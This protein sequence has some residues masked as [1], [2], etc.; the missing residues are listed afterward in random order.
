MIFE[1]QTYLM[2][3]LRR[4]Y[5]LLIGII[6]F[7][8]F[9]ALFFA[10]KWVAATGEVKKVQNQIYILSDGQAWPAKAYNMNMVERKKEIEVFTKWLLD[11][12]FAH[13]RHSLHS[14]LTEALDLI[15][16]KENSEIIFLLNPRQERERYENNN[17][18]SKV[19]IK[20]IKV[21][22]E[23]DENIP[24]GNWEVDVTFYRDFH[25]RDLEKS[26]D[27][28]ETKACELFLAIQDGSRTPE[29]P[30]GIG[31]KEIKEIEPNFK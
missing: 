25:Y 5:L 1:N 22:K 17:A 14:N 21:E 11:K 8:S 20:E 16:N 15:A 6:V 7:V 31:I 12:S 2:V 19:R 10:S 13:D 18:I 30:W 23:K 28:T 26:E 24:S 9:L 4:A 29:N 3:L 27:K